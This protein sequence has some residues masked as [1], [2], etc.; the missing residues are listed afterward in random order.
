MQDINW[1][2]MRFVLTVARTRAIAPAA[3]V[4]HVNETTVARRLRR[5]ELALGSK[6]FERVDGTMRT[7]EAGRIAVQ[8]AERM[9][10]EVELLKAA[11]SGV[12]ASASGI[13]R[14]T[15]IPLV[16]NRLLLP[17]LHNLYAAHP[18]LRARRRA[19]SASPSVKLRLRGSAIASMHAQGMN[20]E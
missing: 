13:V 8:Q 15:S 16:V 5:A 3:R 2:D 17:A 7:T 1:N 4:L 14:V 19:T 6:L 10:V 20:R 11:A 9:E 12:D 18:Q